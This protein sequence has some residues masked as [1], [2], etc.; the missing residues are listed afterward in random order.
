MRKI[1]FF[2]GKILDLVKSGKRK[3]NSIKYILMFLLRIMDK[4]FLIF[5]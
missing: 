1:I 2:V 5:Y 3:E 4:W